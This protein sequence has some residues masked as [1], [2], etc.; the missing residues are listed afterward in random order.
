MTIK[1]NCPCCGGE[2]ELDIVIQPLKD[3]PPLDLP[4]YDETMGMADPDDYEGPP[5]YD[6]ATRTGMYDRGDIPG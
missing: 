5:P 6:D 2:L 1:I 3:G 4:A